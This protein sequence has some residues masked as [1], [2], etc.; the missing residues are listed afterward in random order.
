MQH[1][2]NMTDA[3]V[4]ELNVTEADL[5]FIEAAE[6]DEPPKSKR[7]KRKTSKRKNASDSAPSKASVEATPEV[8]NEPS[9]DTNNDANNFPDLINQVT[10]EQVENVINHINEELGKREDFELSNKV[11]DSMAK[12]LRKLKR[13]MP[14]DPI[15]RVLQATSVSPS[16]INRVMHDG[17]RYNVYAVLK[18]EDLATALAGGQLENAVNRALVRSIFTLEQNNER[19]TS[20]LMEA[21]VSD[22]IKLRDPSKDRFLTRHTVGVSTAPTQKSS[23]MQ[24]LETLG[25]VKVEGSRKHATYQLTDTPQTNRLRELAFAA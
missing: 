20:E 18:L 21:A 13:V 9:N 16:F 15:A 6:V 25:I 3:H 4:E 24:A 17:K 8:D 22:K 1:D 19:I 14:R 11:N 2:T 5:A 23:T 7:S 12:T 10:H